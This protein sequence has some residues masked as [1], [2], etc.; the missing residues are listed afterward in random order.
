[1]IF[2][3]QNSGSSLARVT[4]IIFLMRAE[5]PNNVTWP[6]VVLSSPRLPVEI[7]PGYDIRPDCDVD[8]MLWTFWPGE[9]AGAIESKNLTLR[10]TVNYEDVMGARRQTSIHRKYDWGRSRFHYVGGSE[11]EYQT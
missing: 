10:I 3:V 7:K 6:P 2:I 8:S 1:M 11:F 4:E 5:E 9:E